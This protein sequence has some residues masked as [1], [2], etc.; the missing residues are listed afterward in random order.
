MLT[1]ARAAEGSDSLTTLED[2]LTEL[3]AYDDIDLEA[4][5]TSH[6]PSPNFLPSA[7]EYHA[8]GCLS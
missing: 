6:A 7:E 5:E 4:S 2:D 1:Q 8:M 3:D